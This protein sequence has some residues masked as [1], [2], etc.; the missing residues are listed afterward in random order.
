[1]EN[2]KNTKTYTDVMKMLAQNYEKIE[3]SIVNQLMLDVF[4]HHLTEGMYRENV[5]K[6]LFERIIPKKYCIEQGVFIIDSYE[7]K[8][9]EVDLAIYDELYTPYI[10]NYEGVR[11]IPIEAVAAVVQCKSNCIE[12]EDILEWA[13]SIDKLLTSLD[14][15]TRMATG[16]ADNYTDTREVTQT[17]TR[18][19]KILCALAENITNKNLKKEFD[20]ILTVDK[21]KKKLIKFVREEEGSLNTWNRSL[22]HAME[23]TEPESRELRK[24]KACRQARIYNKDETSNARPRLLQDLKVGQAKE[25]KEGEVEE[26]VLLSLIFQLNQLLM[27]LNNPMLFPHRAYADMFNRILKGYDREQGEGQEKEHGQEK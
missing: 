12:P 15:V 9:R 6:S 3:H 18:P 4:N 27:V 1:M 5:W 7:N 22:N 25:G 10:F 13:K 19:I 20:I 14:S 24:E 11:F 23:G 17:A 21:D 26:N 2:T 8:S 16:M